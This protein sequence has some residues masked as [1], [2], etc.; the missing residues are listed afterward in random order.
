MTQMLEEAI[1]AVKA[2]PDRDQDAIAASILAEIEDDRRWAESF[3]RS[4]DLLAE[5]AQE[6]LEEYRA[7][8]T[9]PLD[10]ERM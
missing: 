8:C 3:A 4:P 6:A 10:P 7:G 2:L 1:R 9:L 5:L